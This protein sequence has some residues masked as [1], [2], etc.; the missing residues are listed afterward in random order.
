MLSITGIYD[1]ER[2]IPKDPIP[3]KKGK[4]SRVII[5]FLESIEERRERDLSDFCG[6]WEDDR[7]AKEIVEDIYDQRK[8]FKL[9]EVEL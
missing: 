7:D 3:L 6:I 1:G 8:N 2:I 5:T 4:S 9:R